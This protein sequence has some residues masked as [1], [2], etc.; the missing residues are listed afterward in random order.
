MS[1]YQYVIDNAQSIKL[2]YQDSISD[3]VSRNG[4]VTTGRIVGT[5]PYQ[6]EVEIAS[7]LD[8]G[9]VEVRQLL[10]YIDQN[11]KVT[12]EI[13]DIG[14]TNTG[15]NY[16]TGYKG[17]A[18][19][20][21]LESLNFYPTPGILDN[22]PRG[23]TRTPSYNILT[24]QEA[25]ITHRPSDVSTTVFAQGDYIQ[26]NYTGST[27]TNTNQQVPYQVMETVQV[28]DLY[29]GIGNKFYDVKVNRHYSGQY[30]AGGSG[31]TTSPQVKVGSNVSFD[32]ALVEKPRYEIIPGGK[33]G[34]IVFSDSFKF[35]EVI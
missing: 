5:R 23:S 18:P 10:Q 12:T 6:L 15:L 27:G 30:G 13:V 29:G 24:M 35:I 2:N 19:T 14:S 28:S 16:I 3:V 31:I 17:N 22:S 4:K 20:A 25:N 8:A 26:F 21:Y 9:N 7:Y 1:N 11:A 33:N 34:L 32:V